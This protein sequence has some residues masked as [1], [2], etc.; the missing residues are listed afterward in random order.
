MGICKNQ[1]KYVK[2]NVLNKAKG[3][4]MLELGDQ[5]LDNFISDEVG[6]N[7]AKPYYA[8]L[9]YN[10]T[11]VDINGKN[12]AV[13][14]DLTKPRSEFN[15]K[16]NIVTNHGTSEHIIDQY[17]VF[18]QLHDWGA[19]DCVYTHIV[20]LTPEEHKAILGRPFPRHGFWEYS[21]KFWVELSKACNY[22]LVS[23]TTDVR[24]PAVKYPVNHY[25]SGT[26]IK[27]KESK[28]V[29]KKTFNDLVNKYMRK[30]NV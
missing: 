1:M 10:H 13:N 11:S 21:T 26:Y 29:D 28:F 8:S 22:E 19:E 4:N 2:E 12:G 7:I 15:N 14:H 20:P 25:S 3:K 16:F 18:K 27:T 6:F 17:G 23:A 5:V 9:G 30:C 24:N